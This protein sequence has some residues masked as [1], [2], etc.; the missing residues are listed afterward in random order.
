M[1]A[2]QRLAEPA[3]APAVA[4]LM[5]AS[6]AE[7]FGAYYDARQV[8]SAI[9]HVAVLDLAL[10]EDGTY[11]VHEADGEI[12]ACGGWSRRNKLFNGS[13]AGADER[14][15]DPAT[16][17]ARI[18][19]MFVRSDWTRRGLGRAIL[20][21]CVD[22]ARAEGFTRLALMATLPGVPLYKSFGFTEVEA[23]ELTMPDGVVLGGVAMERSVDQ[24]GDAR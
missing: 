3:D 20:T 2:A 7:L 22:A 18:R 8:A 12:V 24:I 21:S 23:A 4:E 13:T 15:L 1:I 14:L 17:P 11:Y 6:V 5:R 16:E 9:A 10:I 19:A